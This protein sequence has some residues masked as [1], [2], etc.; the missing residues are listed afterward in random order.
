LN[1][2]ERAFFGLPGKAQTTAL[3]GQGAANA[4]KNST[5]VVVFALP[6]IPKKQH[7]GQVQPPFF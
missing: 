3:A 6:S 5:A 4:F 1:P 2:P 7:F